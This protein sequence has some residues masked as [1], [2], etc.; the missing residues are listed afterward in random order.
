LEAQNQSATSP[1]RDTPDARRQ[2]R[3]RLEVDITIN[4]KTCGVVKGTTVDI[5][6]SGVSARLK[7]E[8]SLGEFVEL[9][10]MLPYGPVTVYAVG[11]QR[12]AFRYG[13]QFVES[14]SMPAIIQ[15]SCQSLRLEQSLFGESKQP[16]SQ[17]NGGLAPG[18]SANL[19]GNPFAKLLR[20]HLKRRNLK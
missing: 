19:V 3:F 10:F 1:A 8:V 9:Q 14:H 16:A 4:T 11:R 13:L 2:P 12:S 17:R 20:K 5:S 15:S 6:E 7:L 18:L